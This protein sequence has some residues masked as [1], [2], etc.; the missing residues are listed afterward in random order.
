RSRPPRLPAS[1]RTRSPPPVASCLRTSR[2]RPLR[3]VSHWTTAD[4][5]VFFT[6]YARAWGH[7]DS[8]P[9]WIAN[10]AGALSRHVLGLLVL[11]VLVWLA[12][13]AVRALERR[14]LREHPVDV[15]DNLRARRGQAQG[16]AGTGGVPGPIR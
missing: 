14:V 8:V 12:V 9:D 1:H 5:K 3:R 2:S 10:A 7:P 15:A 4:L 16:Q 11:L 6:R 13:R